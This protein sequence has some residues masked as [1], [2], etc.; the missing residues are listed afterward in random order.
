MDNNNENIPVEEAVSLS[1]IGVSDR[2]LSIHDYLYPS[3]ADADEMPASDSQ[4]PQSTGNQ[5]AQPQVDS[6]TGIKAS[7]HSTETVNS[8]ESSVDVVAADVPPPSHQPSPTQSTESQSTQSTESQSTQ[9]T[10]RKRAIGKPRQ[11]KAP[12]LKVPPKRILY[13]REMTD[14]LMVWFGECKAAGLFKR[15]KTKKF[16]PAWQY[17]FDLAL[18]KYPNQP[19]TL[20]AIAQKY[21][22]ERKRFV[23]WKKLITTSGVGYDWSSNVPT[24]SEEI[25]DRFFARHNTERK[26][27]HRLR[28]TPL[29]NRDVYEEVFRKERVAGHH[30][31]EAGDRSGDEDGS[32]RDDDVSS[33][34]SDS[35]GD[36]SDNGRDEGEEVQVEQ[37]EVGSTR[38]RRETPTQREARLTD[39]DR[40]PLHNV[41]DPISVKYKRTPRIVNSTTSRGDGDEER[42]SQ[43]MLMAAAVLAAP[44][45]PGAAAFQKAVEDISKRFTGKITGEEMMRVLDFLEANPMTAVKY[46]G[47][48]NEM[49]WMYVNKW[50]DFEN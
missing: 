9:G 41:E 22:T 14:Q 3:I 43:S 16:G 34:S 26:N 35:D 19:W 10:K 12:T 40:T 1:S 50:K 44:E 38:K 48:G 39:P 27:Y 13:T 21:D 37:E 42:L 25:W 31:R 2:D 46:N 29:G 45:L 17:V 15:G 18:E 5:Q 30:I 24:A 7:S 8:S 11:R 33:S 49:R 20:K 32:D 36:G 23:M 6:Q 28:T 47:C 4:S